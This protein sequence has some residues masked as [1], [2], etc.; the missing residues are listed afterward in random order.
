MNEQRPEMDADMEVVDWVGG[1]GAEMDEEFRN[2][3]TVEVGIDSDEDVRP[4]ESDGDAD[5]E[6]NDDGE[7]GVIDEK[8]VY[9]DEELQ[10]LHDDA[11]AH[12]QHQD[13]VL[14]VAFSPADR[15]LFA[16]GGQDD[17]AAL[18]M[19]EEES[20]GMRL[21]QRCRLEGHTDSVIQVE[22]SHDGAYVATGSYDGTVRIWS[23][24]D[25]SLVHSLDGPSKEVEWITW[26]PKGHAILAGS[27]DTMA[28]MWWAPTGKLMQIFAGHA[29]SVTCGCWGLGG[30]LIVT[31]SEDQ[32]VIV[33]NPRAGTPQQ[34]LRQV[35]ESAVTAICAH[36]EAPIVVTGGED[37]VAKVVQIETGKVLASLV[38]HSDSVEH[39]GFNSPPVGGVSLLATGSMDGKVLVW[40]GKTFERRCELRDHVE[41]GGIVHL[42]WLKEAQYS[43]WLC[44][45]STDHTLRL[46]NA[47][48]AQCL[49][50]LSGHSDTVLD[51]DVALAPASAAAQQQPGA[52][53]GHQLYVVSGSDDNSCR[54]FSVA[55]WTAGAAAPASSVAPAAPG[56]GGAVGGMVASGAEASPV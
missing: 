51:L 25:G 56:S 34:H 2:A 50:T 4:Q 39:V 24:M 18:W 26:H 52:Q 47:L 20:S 10:P 14:A 41:R 30:K 45:C 5:L 40:D 46:F 12:V 8:A 29:Q 33:W 55:L 31:G 6:P 32:G 17:M 28:W 9:S 19:L 21:A 7:I 15:R 42:K 1:E 27:N 54:V 53:V 38:G 37:S 48:T 13:S 44:T 3:D 16:T 23:A 49:R 11:G 35:H 22:F 43:S 36:S